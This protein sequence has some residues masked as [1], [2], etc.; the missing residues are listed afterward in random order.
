MTGST[1]DADLDPVVAALR[2]DPAF[3]AGRFALTDDGRGVAER[4]GLDE[5]RL[6]RLLLCKAPTPSRFAADVR[7]IAGLVTADPSALTATLRE[8]EA[9][10]GLRGVRETLRLGSAEGVLAAARDET[11]DHMGPAADREVQLRELADGVWRACPEEVREAR[12]IDAAVAWSAALAL[13]SLPRL[14]VAAVREWLAD[15]GVP[16]AGGDDGVPL[17]GF[18][19]AYRGVG[20]VF[21]DGTLD[22]AERRFTVAHEVGHFLLDYQLPRRRVLRDAPGL[23][24][25]VDG[26][27]PATPSDRAQAVLARVPLGPHT[28]RL[29]HHNVEDTASRFALELLSPLGEAL[30]AVRETTERQTSYRFAL[31]TAAR[32]LADRFQIPPYA[33]RTRA[34]QA[35]DALD[36]HPDFFER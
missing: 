33:A 6:R 12:D 24:E 36:I 1:D 18:L 7:A 26:V 14:S 16:T 9:V 2:D 17:R 23:I 30:D 20:L 31:G 11:D 35:L 19:V 27:R 28:H 8:V 21:V 5:G 3:L 29:G 10:A 4:L 32:R 34:R 22:A 13:V 25:V 15:R